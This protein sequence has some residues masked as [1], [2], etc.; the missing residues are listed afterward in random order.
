MATNVSGITNTTLQKLVDAL[1]ASTKF[2]DGTAPAAAPN[3]FKDRLGNQI[4]ANDAAEVTC[5]VRVFPTH[6]QIEVLPVGSKA[7]AILGE[8]DLAVL[9]TKLA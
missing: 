1:I 9:A 2:K 6:A 4:N 8:C 3:A 5:T 7:N